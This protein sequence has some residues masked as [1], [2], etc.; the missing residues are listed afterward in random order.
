MAQ[1]ELV[2]VMIA[3]VY[4]GHETIRPPVKDKGHVLQSS[5]CAKMYSQVQPEPMWGFNSLSHANQHILQRLTKFPYTVFLDE[6][7]LLIINLQMISIQEPHISF[8]WNQMHFCKEAGLWILTP[9]QRPST[10]EPYWERI[11]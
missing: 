6:G 10:V 8:S 2:A 7:L 1:I 5:F 11:T 9:H 4:M 3:P